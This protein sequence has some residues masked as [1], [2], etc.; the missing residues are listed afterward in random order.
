MQHTTRSV[1]HTRRATRPGRH[2][3][4]VDEHDVARRGGLGG[5]LRRHSFEGEETRRVG[6]RN[7]GVGWTRCR[8]RVLRWRRGRKGG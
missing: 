7:C 1:S 4:H 6:R 5:W 2:L 3:L 8:R